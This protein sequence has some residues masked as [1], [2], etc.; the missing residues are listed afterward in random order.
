MKSV[1]LDQVR[2][3]Q[4]SIAV[5]VSSSFG[6]KD[7]LLTVAWVCPV[8]YLPSKV[9]I[10]VSPER[11]SYNII[12]KS[13]MFAVNILEFDYVDAVYKAGVVSGRD[14]ED[15]FAYCGLTRRRGRKLP[16]SVVGEAIGVLECRV[17]KKVEIDDHDLFIGDVVDAYVKDKYSTFWDP[18][19]Y[20][21]ILY[22]SE[23][24][25]MTIDPKSV[26]KYEV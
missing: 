21:P 23:G 16:I 26:R 12:D 11:F 4:P 25:F 24:H 20:R 13:G 17:I 5:L 6:G 18:E 1:V 15:K 9:A 3:I 2:L 14:V 22:I 8:S 7:A 10:A 19:D